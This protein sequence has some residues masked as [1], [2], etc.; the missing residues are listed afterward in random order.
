MKP[1][2]CAA[3]ALLCACAST[4]LAA[5]IM[6]IAPHPDDDV[7]I[8][9]GI[10][11]HA[12]SRGDSVKVVYMTNGDVAGIAA[13]LRRQ[14][15]AVAG[16][17][18]I[19][20]VESNLIFLGYPDG[21]LQPMTASYPN[22]TDAYTGRSGATQTYGSRGLGGAD[23]H[24]YKTGSPALYNRPNILADLQSVIGTYLPEHIVTLSQYD[25]HLDHSTTNQLVK[26]ATNSV[27]AAQSGYSPTLHTAIVWVDNPG[28]P[29]V[30]PESP[31]PTT[32]IAAPSTLPSA[33]SWETRE[34]IDV[35]VVMQTPLFATNPKY[36]AIDQH[37]A[38][39]TTYLGRFVH[40][41]EVFWAERLSGAAPLHVD[42]NFNQTVSAAASVQ[43]NGAASFDPSGGTLTYRW[44]QVGGESVALSGE[45]T[46]TPTFI[47]PALESVDK[48]LNFE[49][50]VGDSSG[51]NTTLPDLVAITVTPAPPVTPNATV[52]PPSSSGGGGGAMDLISLAFFSTVGG[53]RYQKRRPKIPI[54]PTIIK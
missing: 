17:Q 1:T 26:L 18:I 43:L 54:T 25:R 32:Y 51:A 53:L 45:N 52:P 50:V 19:G 38:G 44:R 27:I 7:L 49:L 37:Q 47:A 6:V 41:D 15:E 12:I 46:A 33:L 31:N 3:C 28:L 10:V 22:A 34:S 13:G 24:T 29:P 39:A 14:S 9:A 4:S 23:Y 8:A 42:A 40:K 30:W 21:G 5:G 2:F 48:V 16:Q 36:H 11:S 20:D 35:P